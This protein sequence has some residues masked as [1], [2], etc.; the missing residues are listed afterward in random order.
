MVARWQGRGTELC[1]PQTHPRSRAT[2]AQPRH[3]DGQGLIVNQTAAVHKPA[4]LS[5]RRGTGTAGT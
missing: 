2:A 3:G 4:E 5:I 1:Q